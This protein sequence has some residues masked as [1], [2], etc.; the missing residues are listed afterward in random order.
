MSVVCAKKY[1]DK[2]VMCADSIVVS[3]FSKT[4]NGDFTKMQYINNMLLGGSG[5]ADEISVMWHYMKTHKPADNSDKSVLEF[6]VEFSKWKND[7]GMGSR[8]DNVYLLAYQEKLFEIE[9]MFV[10]EIKDFCAIGAGRDF[11][12]AAMYLGH[13]PREAVKVACALS[14]VVAEPILEETMM[15]DKFT[16]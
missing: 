3:G 7:M 10:C 5:R 15:Y 4:T 16:F 6:I 12:N 8:I 2:I 13:T 9:D 14:C 1:K 11:S